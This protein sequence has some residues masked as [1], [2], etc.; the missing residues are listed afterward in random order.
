MTTK[1]EVINHV[2]NT[3]GEDPVSSPTSNH[4]SAAAARVTIDRLSKELQIRG[5]WY[6]KEYDLT[7]LPDGDGN[8][9][10]PSNTLRA[11]ITDPT[12]RLIW[13]GS[14]LYDPVNHTFNIGTSVVIDV[15]VQLD[16]EDMPESAA[17]YLKHKA[18]HEFYV[19]DDGDRDK[20]TELEKRVM[21]AWAEFYAE[22]LRMLK[23]GIGTNPSVAEMRRGTMQRG[24]GST[25]PNW[26]GG[27]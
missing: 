18:A 27:R 13:R 4:P 7:L 23:L 15:V 20:A 6:N 2:L 21:F 19:N 16:M 5:W 9:I 24:G 1:L 10:L 11:I 12:S 25:N 14:K 26:P 8:I 17:T 3:V 22:H